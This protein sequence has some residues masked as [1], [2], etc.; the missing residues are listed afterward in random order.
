MPAPGPFPLNAKTTRKISFPGRL[1]L[2]Q[3]EVGIEAR[4]EFVRELLPGDAR[5]LADRTC[6]DDSLCVVAGAEIGQRGLRRMR[7][8]AAAAGI[9]TAT[10]AAL[11]AGTLRLEQ[12][13]YRLR[14]RADGRRAGL[15][16]VQNAV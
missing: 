14:L 9:G 2:Q 8:A 13:L 6:V 12:K 10:A 3:P 16:R 4:L 7:G 1:F 15:G 5:G 11:V